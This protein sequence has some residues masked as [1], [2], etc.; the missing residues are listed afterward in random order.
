MPE[1]P[2][3]EHMA[4][5]ALPARPAA[6]AAAWVRPLLIALGYL[7][8]FAGL[9]LAYRYASS[10]HHLPDDGTI[11]WYP[12]AGLSLGLV[13]VFG[14]RYAPLVL[15]AT[16][17]SRFID[18]Q[19]PTLA[20]SLLLGSLAMLGYAGAAAIFRYTLRVDPHLQRLKD[21][22]GLTVVALTA[23]L[24]IDVLQCLVRVALHTVTLREAFAGLSMHWVADMVGVMALTPF[25]VTHLCA[26][27]T[28]LLTRDKVTLPPATPRRRI[29]WKSVLLFCAWTLPIAAILWVILLSPM[30]FRPFYLSF[31]LLIWIALRHGM[32]GAT[33]TM[34]AFG[35]GTILIVYLIGAPSI[36]PAEMQVFILTLTLTGLLLGTIISERERSEA[37]VRENEERLL[38]LIN[39]M[40]D[41]VVFKDG[42]GRWLQANNFSRGFFHLDA[43]EYQGK[44][45]TEL[46][47]LSP[48]YRK[49]LLNSER[50]DHDAWASEHL[51]RREERVPGTDGSTL[52]FDVIKVPL[53]D[54]DGQRKG[55]VV[56]GRDITERKLAEEALEMERA[57]LSSAIDILP[58]P[59]AFYSTNGDCT[60]ANA[61]C[62]ALFHNLPPAEWLSCEFRLS[63]TGAAVPR[64]MLPVM[65]ALQGEVL[66]SVEGTLHFPDGRVVPVLMHA[67][68]VKVGGRLVAALVAFQDITALKE[69]DRAKD[70][71]LGFFSH[72]LLSPVTDILGWAREAKEAPD[73][74]PQALDI[75]ERNAMRQ[76]RILVDLL[77]VSRV[78]HGRLPLNRR[79]TELWTLLEENL[80]GFEQTARELRRTLLLEA[81]D[82]PLHVN[83]DRERL[84]QVIGNLL[85]NAIK[86][87]EPGDA[88]TITA[89]Q[90]GNAAVLT[91]S[92]SGRGI[93][94]ES[95]P[96]IFQPFQ[97]SPAGHTDHELGLKLALVKGIVQLHGGDVT[98]D[99]AGS[100]HGCTF[101][102]QLPLAENITLDTDAED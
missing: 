98:V 5:S 88:I 101:T 42:E 76:Y 84:R 72:E 52:I 43:V 54:A 71:F 51:L 80:E 47:A 19:P 6:G 7:A 63:G 95:L 13:L 44:R 40:P 21:V 28:P 1:A 27:G 78:T 25:L 83:L 70:E 31:L 67:G 16:V 91:V 12:T 81:P 93:P 86:N 22:L 53:R 8:V 55:L 89:C 14:L 87:T 18:T 17:L 4:T 61:A 34:L 65:R 2:V 35:L 24:V 102:I 46:A 69:A 49:T 9:Q 15:V 39:A 37:S 74:V 11:L 10:Q 75:I 38:T 26:W 73:F 36:A 90:E 32:P 64:D 20:A 68:P 3:H 59:L 57:Y 29:S 56:I 92:D 62:E 23:P 85:A 94:P 100:K 30:E 41:I 96:Y 60:Q 33:A 79:R 97:Q 50:T 58:V 99:S 45:G 77:D 66:P 48:A 82:A